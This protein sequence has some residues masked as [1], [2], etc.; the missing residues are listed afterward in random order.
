MLF[1]LEQQQRKKKA[2]AFTPFFYEFSFSFERRINYVTFPWNNISRKEFKELLFIYICTMWH[3]TIKIPLKS[4][5]QR[6]YWSYCSRSVMNGIENCFATLLC[7]S[8]KI[9]PIDVNLHGRGLH[10][11]ETVNNTYFYHSF[12]KAFIVLF[13]N[14]D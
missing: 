5:R 1:K 12:L 8:S 3:K 4:K 14:C 7:F 10:E 13:N 2:S 11:G 6:R 9:S